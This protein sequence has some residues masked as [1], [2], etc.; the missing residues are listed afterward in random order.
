MID[1]HDPINRILSQKNYGTQ[2]KIKYL[3]NLVKNASGQLVK[4]KVYDV[5]VKSGEVN[6]IKPDN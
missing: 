5:F 2:K 4:L 6:T 3:V 1:K